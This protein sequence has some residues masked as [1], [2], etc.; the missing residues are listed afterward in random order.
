MSTESELLFIISPW[1]ETKSSFIKL[2]VEMEVSSVFEFL[3]ER[4]F[5]FSNNISKLDVKEECR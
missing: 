1:R 4:A 3:L 2:I 5:C